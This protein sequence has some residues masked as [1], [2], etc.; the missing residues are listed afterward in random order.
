MSSNGL[1]ALLREQ[2]ASTADIFKPS[3]VK[4]EY[5]RVIWTVS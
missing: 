3:E 4:P 5:S 2:S 1:D